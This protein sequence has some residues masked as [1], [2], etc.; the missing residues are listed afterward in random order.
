M[1]PP[2]AA[3]PLVI[4]VLGAPGAGKG[5]QGHLLSTAF[6]V[7]H[8]S[9]GELLREHQQRSTPLGKAAR[10]YMERGELLPDDLVSDLVFDRLGRPDAMSGA[11][12]DGFPRTLVQAQKLDEWIRQRGADMPVV[13]YLDVPD[14]ELLERLGRRQLRPTSGAVPR[15]DDRPEVADARLDVFWREM[16][17]V[18]EEYQQRALRRIDGVGSPEVVHERIMRALSS[19]L[20]P[21]ER[22]S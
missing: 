16:P 15:S 6:G 17:P 14:G 7:P 3:N 1:K 19:I 20:R 22:G 12:L 11:V 2:R 4:L 10:S 13:L 9:T 21:A 5:T 18:L 8:I